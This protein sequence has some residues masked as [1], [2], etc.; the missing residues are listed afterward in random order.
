MKMSFVRRYQL[1][2]SIHTIF[3]IFFWTDEVRSSFK[4]FIIK[5][6]KLLRLPKWLSYFSSFFERRRVFF[7][8]PKL[9]RNAKW[10]PSSNISMFGIGCNT[11]QSTEWLLLFFISIEM[12]PLNIF[13][14]LLSYLFSSLIELTVLILFLNLERRYRFLINFE[15]KKSSSKII[16]F[17]QHW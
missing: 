4:R 17:L 2:T 3:M 1:Y 7:I 12:S 10:N 11:D 6:A 9:P 14:C 5:Q 8:S 13:L 16:F 15:F